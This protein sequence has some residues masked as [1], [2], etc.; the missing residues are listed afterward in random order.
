M[1]E[2]ISDMVATAQELIAEFGREITLQHPYAEPL[3]PTKPWRGS[4]GIG[5][6]TISVIGVFVKSKMTAAAGEILLRGQQTVLV[7]PTQNADDLTEFTEVV[8]TDGTIWIV[9]ALNEVNPGGTTV[10][11]EFTVKR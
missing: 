11:W 4:P 5:Y 8:D 9:S 3:D 2:D 1:P 7:A 10:L 6:N